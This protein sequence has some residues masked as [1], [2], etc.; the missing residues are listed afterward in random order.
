[1]E[2]IAEEPWRYDV[3]ERQMMAEAGITVIPNS[4]NTTPKDTIIDDTQRTFQRSF[5]RVILKDGTVTDGN[6]NPVVP[7][8]M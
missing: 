2:H 4:V 3:Y 6:G 7:R 1:M 8:R 5:M